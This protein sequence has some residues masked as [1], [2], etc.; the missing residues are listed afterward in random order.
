V[1][2]LPPNAH[3]SAPLWFILRSLRLFAGAWIRRA[4]EPSPV[5]DPTTGK[6]MVEPTVITRDERERL[7]A[8]CTGSAGEQAA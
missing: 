6:P 2:E 8:A 1:P 3:P 7:R 5:F 4:H